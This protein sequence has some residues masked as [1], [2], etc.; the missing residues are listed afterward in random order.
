MEDDPDEL[1]RT[2]AALTAQLAEVSAAVERLAA[3]G[4]A[5]QPAA[6]VTP[7]AGS[8]LASPSGGPAESFAGGLFMTEPAAVPRSGGPVGP[9][10]G[11]WPAPPGAVLP[12]VAV[13]GA[14]SPGV[15]V[16]G[17]VLPGAGV[18]PAGLPA[19]AQPEQPR[20]W[21]DTAGLKILGW[22]GGGVTVLGIVMLLVVAAQQGLIGPL[23]RVFIGA[24]LGAMLIAGGYLLHRK[25]GQ[26]ALAA[27]IVCTGIA[28]EYLSAIGAVRLAE[29]VPPIVGHGASILIVAVAVA[30]AVSWREPW[31][32]GVS[33]AA[34]GLLA[35]LVGGGYPLG[36]YLF[37]LVMVGG[38]AACLLLGLG[39]YAWGGAGLAAAFTV[40]VGLAAEPVTA[41]DLWSVLMMA[42]ISWALFIGRWVTGR[43]PVD[44]GP[45]PI[46]PRSADPAQ[47]ARDYADFHAHQRAR[48]A[49]RIDHATAITSLAIGTALAAIALAVL[50]PAGQR[51]IPAGI[52]AV[53]LAAVTGLLAVT[54]GRHEALDRPSVRVVTW[55]AMMLFA[56]VALLRLLE[57]DI[58]S[59]SWVVLATVVLVVIAAERMIWLLV[60]G[61]IA[62]ALALL[63][64][65]PALD[66]EDLFLWPPYGLIGQ[67]GLLT[68][69][70]AVVLPAGLCVLALSL[71][72]WWATSRVTAARLDAVR[73]T[74]A[75]RAQTG[76]EYGWP[77]DDAAHAERHRTAIMGWTLVGCATVA[78]YGLLA[79][80]MV[81]AYAISPTSAG[82]QAGQIV[83]TVLVTVIALGL[84]WQGFRRLIVRIGGLGL[85]AVAVGK[86]LL[87][88]TRTLED[89]PRAI[90]VIGVGVLLLIGAVMY[91]VT[92]SRLHSATV[93]GAPPPSPPEEPS[94]I[95]NPGPE[96][97]A[98]SDGDFPRPQ[99]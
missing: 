51:S 37:E 64:A 80:T 57:G 17:A 23:A 89:L 65:G 19:M 20:S 63:A 40:L 76:Y 98:S 5:A 61:L 93:D 50:E 32:A 72:A 41:A 67:D 3:Q 83:V 18:A 25:Q 87:F 85:A 66:P 1:R 46:R 8:V 28:V 10:A 9:F 13:S 22:V 74:L 24:V 21:A 7:P 68:R 90:T 70:W 16:P 99:P 62:G 81:L 84:L 71:A 56:G 88:D 82:Y 54:A 91:V 42:A 29:L 53:V 52:T 38:G 27:T 36:I 34:S 60:P 97:W 94:T 86:L 73:S 33:F 55:I 6:F 49:A 11:A 14:V 44:P 15:A 43:A 35:P 59:V 26:R 45:F 2:L 4:P 95:A 48:D 31:L 58:R 75:Q 39:L 77:A 96:T 92:L 79:V 12:G 30:I 78:C 69:G 47:I